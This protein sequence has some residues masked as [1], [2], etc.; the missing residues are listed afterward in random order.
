MPAVRRGSLASSEGSKLSMGH[1]EIERIYRKVYF[2][3]AVEEDQELNAAIPGAKYWIL[4][5][6]V[7]KLGSVHG[8]T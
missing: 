7:P 1:L 5:V 4:S 8:L 6:G 2:W 3:G